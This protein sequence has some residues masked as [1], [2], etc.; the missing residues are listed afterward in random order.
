MQL[1]QSPIVLN[2]V[3]VIAESAEEISLCITLEQSDLTNGGCC[4]RAQHGA[5][6]TMRFP[7]TPA[8]RVASRFRRERKSPRCGRL[9]QGSDQ[10]YVRR[11]R[12]SRYHY[13]FG[14]T[15]AWRRRANPHYS[16]AGPPRL[17]PA[18]PQG[19]QACREL[20]K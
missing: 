8:L 18:P 7:L 13:Q 2:P 11:E 19:P 10:H 12:R 17:T 15:S 14:P 6:P 5:H 9:R 20:G 1:A 3:A 16:D 4:E